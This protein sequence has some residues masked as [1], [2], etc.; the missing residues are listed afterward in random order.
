ME[1]NCRLDYTVWYLGCLFCTLQ[2]LRVHCG[3]SGAPGMK[4]ASIQVVCDGCP[5]PPYF[6]MTAVRPKRKQTWYQVPRYQVGII[7]AW[8]LVSC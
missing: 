5:L 6:V 2:V 3:R 4:T 1:G 7:N 8:Y